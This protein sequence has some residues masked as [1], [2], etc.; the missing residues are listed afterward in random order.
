MPL[1][2]PWL[3]R[4]FDF[5]TPVGMYP[6]L[7][8]RLRGA[9]ARL[10]DHIRGLSADV[11]TRRDGKTWSI[12]ENAGHLLEIDA[13]PAKRLDDF[14]AGAPMLSAWAGNNDA[15]DAARF[16]D[17]DINEITAGFRSVRTALVDRLDA[18]CESDFAR[19]STHPRLNKP[20]RII[21]L[22]DFHAQHDD[23][24]LATI[25]QLKRLFK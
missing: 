17:R 25:A 6:D 18:L 10:E 19:S 22:C 12:Q 9:P 2:F 1:P 5:D 15:T 8:E 13:L 24:H 23:Y 20:M 16:N 7:V 14:L 11:L 4:P 3:E 21:D